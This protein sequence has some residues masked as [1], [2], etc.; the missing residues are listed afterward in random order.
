MIAR[1][2]GDWRQLEKTVFSLYENR[3]VYSKLM[4]IHIEITSETSAHE[5]KITS[6]EGKRFETWRIGQ[7]PNFVQLIEKSMIMHW[8]ICIGICNSAFG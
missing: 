1:R 7:P 4:W 2:S 3:Q 8:N 6:Q 5:Q